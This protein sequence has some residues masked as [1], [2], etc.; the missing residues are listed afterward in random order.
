MKLATEL[1]HPSDAP[2]LYILDEPTTGLHFADVERLLGVLE[3]LADKGHT[4]VV[5]EHNLDVVKCADWIVDLGP[6]GGDGGGMVVASGTP[7][8]VAKAKGSWTGKW[9]KPLLASG[10]RRANPANPTTVVK[11][12]LAASDAAATADSGTTA[13]R[14]PAKATPPKVAAKASVKAANAKG[15]GRGSAAAKSAIEK[16]AAKQSAT[17][18]SATKQPAVKKSATKHAATK[19]SGTKNSGTKTSGTPRR[20][21]T[22]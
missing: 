7:E 16:P 18:N 20:A 13:R 5:I 22:R 14:A 17:G 10:P 6:E 19:D 1:G 15:T 2:A 9:L 11:A 4:L 12:A 3:R 8:E 21:T